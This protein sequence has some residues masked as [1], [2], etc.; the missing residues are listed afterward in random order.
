MSTEQANFFV[1]YERAFRDGDPAVDSKELEARAVAHIRG[2][3]EAIMRGDF[4]AF[5]ASLAEDAEMEIHG[6]AHLPI[7]G[8]WRGRQNVAEAVRQNFGHVADQK[9]EIQSLC[10][11]GDTV[12]L[13]GRERGRFTASGDEYN[14]TWIQVHTVRDGKTVCFRQ[15]VSE[16]LDS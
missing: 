12:V 15:Y 9:P 11:Q 16:A 7:R 3:I 6:P 5:A 13:V 8:R 4:A 2:Q 14:V 1:G 10:A